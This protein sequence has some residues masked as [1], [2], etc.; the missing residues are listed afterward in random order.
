MY[1]LAE[2]LDEKLAGETAEMK[3]AP[4]VLLSAEQLAVQL[5]DALDAQLVVR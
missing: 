5:A 3:A 1:P 4:W 2:Q